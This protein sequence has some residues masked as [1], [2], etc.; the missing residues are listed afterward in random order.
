MVKFHFQRFNDK[1]VQTSYVSKRRESQH[2]PHANIV[3]L[4]WSHTHTHRSTLAY[5][6]T[7][8]YNTVEGYNLSLD[9]GHR[10]CNGELNKNLMQC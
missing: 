1:F 5:T 3:L 6:R 4:F 8:T 2:L 7:N 9:N 10:D